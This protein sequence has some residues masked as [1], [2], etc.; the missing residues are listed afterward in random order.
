[1]TAESDGRAASYPLLVPQ[2]ARRLR[3]GTLLNALPQP[4]SAPSLPALD[5]RVDALLRRAEEVRGLKATTIR[6][7]R[8]AYS[9]LRTFL[10]EQRAERDFLG[11]DIR[12][13]I[14]I[15]QR[16]VGWQR[17][18]GVHTVAINST[19]RG[20]ASVFRWLGDEDGI[21]SPFAVIEPPRFARRTPSFLPRQEAER[22]LV[23][24][25]NFQWPSQLAR[26][27]NLA[28]VG[29]MLLAGLRRGEVLR[30]KVADVDLENGRIRVLGAKGMYGGK[31][32]VS[33]MPPLL[34]SILRDYLA[35]RRKATPERTHPEL[36]THLRRNRPVD[37]GSIQHLFRKLSR[38]IGS[39][40]T[41]HMLRHTYAT[42]LRQAGVEDRISMELLGHT[43]LAMLQ[44]YSHVENGEARSAA[45][46][47]RLNVVL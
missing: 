42:L 26:H 27:R 37:V 45:E 44:R 3:F 36:L 46:K 5:A 1:M 35:V 24:I 43:S 38:V 11:G 47:L 32:R 10:T 19:W 7:A 15:L 40:V 31:D 14:E 41:P 18:R 9:S 21:L 16:W 33:W 30:L 12:R 20:A 25:S 39:R 34:V 6:W 28:L 22:L 17:A 29:L 4:F 2:R 8:Q 13:Q 23:G